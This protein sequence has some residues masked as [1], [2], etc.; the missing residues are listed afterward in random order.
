MS[1]R[2]LWLQKKSFPRTNVLIHLQISS[3]KN[4]TTTKQNKTKKQPPK[5]QERAPLKP[6]G[7][8]HL[9]SSSKLFR[10]ASRQGQRTMTAVPKNSGSIQISNGAELLATACLGGTKAS[11]KFCVS[12]PHC[13]GVSDLGL[14]QSAGV[15]GIKR[16][17][18][19]PRGQRKKERRRQGKEGPEKTGERKWER[20][21]GG[22]E[23]KGYYFFCICHFPAISHMTS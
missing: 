17:T 7:G 22:G 6:S 8:F 23:M 5:T 21:Q 9:F 20:V 16:W 3:A 13:T 14:F 4:P 11:E 1:R 18:T 12:S 15:W 19:F 10:H 2:C